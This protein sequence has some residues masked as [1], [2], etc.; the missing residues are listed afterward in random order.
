VVAKMLSRSDSWGRSIEDFQRLLFSWLIGAVCERPVCERLL[1][2]TAS[3]SPGGAGVGASWLASDL[4][5]AGGEVFPWASGWGDMG[6]TSIRLTVGDLVAESLAN[7]AG[8]VLRA[9]ARVRALGRGGDTAES[10]QGRLWLARVRTKGGGVGGWGDVQ[11][12][13]F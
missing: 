5:D 2:V 9:V 3:C 6:A 12:R 1:G 8:R 10:Q 13:S 11:Q 4:T 7:I